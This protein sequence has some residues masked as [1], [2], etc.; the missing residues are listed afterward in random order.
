M[1][2]KKRKGGLH[3]RLAK[4]E[5]EQECQSALYAL[6]MIQ[7]AKGLMSGA[8]I[9]SIATAAQQDLENVAQGFKI[10]ELKKIASLVH[11]KN[12]GPSLTTM[13]A[14]ESNLPDPLQVHIPMKGSVD[15]T[16]SAAILLPHE[17]FAAMCQKDEAWAKCILPDS[18]RLHGFWDSFEGH[19]C[20]QSH[21]CTKK[22][23]WK[24]LTIPLGLHGDEVPVL[25]TGKIWCK[26][27][28]VFSWF[29]IMA[30]A[31]GAGYQ[32]AHLYI[33]GIFEK[34]VVPAA[35]SVLGTMEVFWKIMKW[36]FSALASGKYP[37]LDWQGQP[38]P[39]GSKAARRG[40]NDL[41]EGY[42]AV[43]LQLAGDLDYYNKWLET[44][45]VTN[46]E[47]PCPLCRASFEGPMSYLDNRKDSPWQVSVLMP[48]NYREHWSPKG[49][50]Y[51]MAGFSNQCLAMDFMHTMHLGWLQ[52]FFRFCYPF[53][54]VLC[55]D[56]RASGQPTVC[57]QLHQ[58]SPEDEQG[59]AP[60]QDEIG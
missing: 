19:P 50:L 6:L 29:C 18:A 9:H 40:G 59:K 4:A 48:S 10:T 38:F 30:A 5:E 11:A 13:M 14:K 39:V 36:S 52:H 20:M 57:V 25:G 58:T 37:M 46:H 35:G 28:L 26:C 31:G 42:C 34:Y 22:R 21:P 32:D 1:A 3:Q 41:A 16:P 15:Y 49:P 53:T 7:F 56:G 43:L 23:G 55:A 51:T 60:I 17:Y 12:L 33:W 24:D 54:C 44:P 2:P 47:K 45:R 27:A 8:L